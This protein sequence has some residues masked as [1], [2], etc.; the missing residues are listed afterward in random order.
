MPGNPIPTPSTTLLAQVPNPMAGLIP[1]S[2]LNNATV[3]YQTLLTQY[4]EFTG[5]TEST[6]S[7]GSSLYNSMQVSVEKRLAH[8]LQGRVSFTWDKIMQQTG[9]LNGGQDDWSQ[10]VRGQSGEPTKILN[11]SLTYMLP[12]FANSK[13]FLRKAL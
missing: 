11:V 5:V 10:L 7:I 4:P 3:S 2:S 6:H 8:G 13:G 12:I 9:Y 1:G